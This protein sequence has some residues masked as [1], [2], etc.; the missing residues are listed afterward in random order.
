MDVFDGKVISNPVWYDDRCM[1]MFKTKDKIYTVIS[2]DYQAVKDSIF[3]EI[4]QRVNIIGEC[5]DD[6]V[7][8]RISRIVFEGRCEYDVE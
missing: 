2:G 1:Y 6:K 8:V 3:I 7:Y 4:G 5:I